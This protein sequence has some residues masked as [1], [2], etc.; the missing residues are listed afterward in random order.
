MQQ[1]TQQHQ[2]IGVAQH[3]QQRAGLIGGHTHGGGIN[4]WARCVDCFH[5]K[6]Y[7]AE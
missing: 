5:K 4:R 6:H 1:L 2:P 3:A 7:I